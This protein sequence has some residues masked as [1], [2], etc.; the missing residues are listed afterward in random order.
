MCFADRRSAR[1]RVAGTEIAYLRRRQQPDTEHNEGTPMHD[2]DRAM[3]ET[4]SGF[5]FESNESI[6]EQGNEAYESQEVNELESASELLGVN[7]EAELEQFLGDLVRSA[8]SAVGGF[9][10]SAAGRAVGGVLKTAAKQV[11][12]QVGQ[13]LGNVV[14]PGVGGQL[15]QRA[16]QWLGGRFELEGLSAEDREFE[17]ARAFVRFANETART[18]ATAPPGAPATQ[19]ARAAAI[20]A[21]R[22]TLPALVPAL[23][24]PGAATSAGAA[25]GRW[26]RRG[27]QIVILGA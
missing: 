14:A 19:V 5:E 23:Q 7:S 4:E 11:L 8:A 16:G 25:T 18:A 20:T 21:A 26:V 22:T 13:I 9:A 1:V 24:Q 12:P 15:G 10:N 6:G 17:T 2:I 27:H 3:F